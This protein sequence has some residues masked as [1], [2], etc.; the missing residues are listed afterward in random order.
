MGG[1]GGTA[2]VGFSVVCMGWGAVARVG[3]GRVGCGVR[4]GDWRAASS[5]RAPPG[6][7]LDGALPP[8]HSCGIGRQRWALGWLSRACQAA[9]RKGRQAWLLPPSCRRTT[10]THGVRRNPLPRPAPPP[11]QHPKC[12]R[13]RVAAPPRCPPPHPPPSAVHSPCSS[14]PW[15][16]P[17]TPALHSK[18][19][20]ANGAKLLRAMLQMPHRCR[21][22]IHQLLKHMADDVSQAKLYVQQSGAAI[23]SDETDDAAGRQTTRQGI[24]H[25]GDLATAKGPS[26]NAPPAGRAW[27]P[28]GDAQRGAQTAA[29]L[30]T[31]LM[32][33]RVKHTAGPA[34]G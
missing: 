19:D 4:G 32:S 23:Y 6:L 11:P 12:P 13:P 17:P 16:G 20:G 10:P 2:G 3:L 14:S 29:G 21:G 27:Q 25:D 30:T 34:H 22:K 1:E 24:H 15:R 28:Q 9:A 7:L 31:Q 8:F 33:R 5:A 26:P 18:A